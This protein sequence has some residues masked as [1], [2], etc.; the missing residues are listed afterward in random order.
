MKSEIFG[1][2]LRVERPEVPATDALTA[3]LTSFA[4]CVIRGRTPIVDGHAAL[5]A[6]EAADRVL[7][8]VAAHRWNGRETGPI[9][10]FMTTTRRAAA[11]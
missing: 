1:Q 3:E 6:L 10:P 2:Y 9:G 4:D 5:A 11:A 8:S 7:Q